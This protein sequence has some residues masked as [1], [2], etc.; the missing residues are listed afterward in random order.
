MAFE[1]VIRGGTIDAATIAN[2]KSEYSTQ[3]ILVSLSVFVGSVKNLAHNNGHEVW[4]VAAGCTHGA[5]TAV[6]RKHFPAKAVLKKNPQPNQ[7]H[8]FLLSGITIEE[9][10]DLFKTHGVAY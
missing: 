4:Q 8:H 3:D 10:I 9:F 6:K 7:P 5:I 2:R 1:V